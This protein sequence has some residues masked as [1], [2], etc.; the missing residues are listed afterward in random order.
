[1]RGRRILGAG[2]LL[3]GAV[4]SGFALAGKKPVRVSADDARPSPDVRVELGGGRWDCEA[5]IPR[6]AALTVDEVSWIPYRG[7]RRTV[8]VARPEGSSC[9]SLPASPIGFVARMNETAYES[10]REHDPAR[11]ATVPQAELSLLF[12]SQG[13]RNRLPGLVAFLA[14]AAGLALAF[15]GRRPSAA[16]N[17]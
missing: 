6:T 13:R 11:W 2:L 15:A 1:M 12:P 10:L 17:Q 3:A 9:E 4:A 8:L 5:A 16:A 14:V 7:A